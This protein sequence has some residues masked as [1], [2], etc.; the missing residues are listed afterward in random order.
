MAACVFISI[1]R[2]WLQIS[3]TECEITPL[4]LEDCEIFTLAQF[5][6][7]KVTPESAF[8]SHYH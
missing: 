5:L 3:N 1:S 8:F 4:N 7:E 6:K 2:E